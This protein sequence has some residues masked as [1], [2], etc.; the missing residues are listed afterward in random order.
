MQCRFADITVIYI[1]GSHNMKGVTCEI[2]LILQRS[3]WIFHGS[4]LRFPQGPR[5]PQKR[6]E[7]RIEN[8]ESV[9][10]PQQKQWPEW[11]IV[12]EVYKPD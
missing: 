6:P 7:K 11:A 12:Q 3:I 1:M 9:L 8:R 10:G 5:I 2:F 4:K